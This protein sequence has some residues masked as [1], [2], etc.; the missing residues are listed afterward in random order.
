MT[1]C[2]GELGLSWI[3][4]LVCVAMILLYFQFAAIKHVDNSFLDGSFGLSTSRTGFIGRTPAHED[5]Y[6]ERGISGGIHSRSTVG[7]AT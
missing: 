6:V 1:G 5:I 4:T 7:R 3:D 2:P